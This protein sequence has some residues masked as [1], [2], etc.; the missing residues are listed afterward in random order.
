MGW[1]GSRSA[2]IFLLLSLKRRV[3]AVHGP[4]STSTVYTYIYKQLLF[5]L[6]H[7]VHRLLYPP[8]PPGG[9]ERAATCFR[10]VEM[11]RI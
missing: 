4:Q 2:P 5:I 8:P 3:P 11:F 7:A 1:A 9:L 10:F 6:L